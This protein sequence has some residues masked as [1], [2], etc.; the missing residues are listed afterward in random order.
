MFYFLSEFPPTV[1]AELVQYTCSG[2]ATRYRESEPRIDM[3]INRQ[4]EMCPSWSGSTAYEIR[5]E[6]HPNT[7]SFASL[8]HIK[9]RCPFSLRLFLRIDGVH[10]SLLDGIRWWG[11][12]CTRR[13]LTCVG[14]EEGHWL[15]TID[16]RSDGLNF[17]SRP[18][19]TN[20]DEGDVGPCRAF[21][22]AA[23]A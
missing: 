11:P 14:A 15:G 6:D 5:C 21:G 13:G 2:N 9:A 3:K 16:G 12:R 8:E 4:L 18:S 7:A 1:M 23:Q 19:S 20:D 10:E 17:L 22:V